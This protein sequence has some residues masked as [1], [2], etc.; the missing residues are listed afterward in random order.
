MEQDVKTDPMKQLEVMKTVAE[1]L[2]GID[3]ESASRV[4][5]WASELFGRTSG[6]RP[7]SDSAALAQGETEVGAGKT[8]PDLASLFAA[9]APSDGPERALVVGYWHQVIQKQEDLDA[10]AIN[11]ELKHLGHQ[12][13]NVTSTLGLLM[14]QKPAMVVQVRKAGSTRQ[15]RKKY[16]L[17]TEGI[18]RVNEMLA[19]GQGG[20]Q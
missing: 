5:R 10:Q 13:S 15:A 1:A 8:F 16:R 2:S 20:A 12:L 14:K 3:P 9:A 18:K 6:R 7:A 17:T 19:A 4:I 11:A